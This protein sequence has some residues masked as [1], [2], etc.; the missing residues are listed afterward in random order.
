MLVKTTREVKT[1]ITQKAVHTCILE[2]FTYSVP[3]WRLEQTRTN[4]GGQTI[5]NG[6]DNYCKKPDNA[7]N[8]A[9]RAISPVWK[10]TP[11]TIL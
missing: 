4:R 2:I 8:A 1:V 7:E 5:Q 9:L 11:I 6:I 10:T 3:V